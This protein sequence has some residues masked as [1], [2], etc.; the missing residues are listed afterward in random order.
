MVNCPIC[1]NT[2]PFFRI[3][4]NLRQTLW[5]G[6]TCGFC[7]SEINR[8]GELLEKNNKGFKEYEDRLYQ[9]EYLKE[10]ARLQARKESK[11]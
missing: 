1:K 9:E 2:L 10:K 7:K 8:K 3:P 4:T 11:K 6:W 5:G